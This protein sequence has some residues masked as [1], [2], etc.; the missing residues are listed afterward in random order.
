V[1]VND[2]GTL[3]EANDLRCVSLEHKL[4]IH[5]SP[6]AVMSYGDGG[7][8]LGYL[9]GEPH[10]GLEYM[11][12]MMNNARLGVG[13]QGVGV[14][15][16]AYQAARAYAFE[17]VQSRPMDGST[18]DPV[19]IAHHPDVRR[20]LLS[21][22]ALAET[23]R[24][25]TYYAASCLD[26]AK[27]H[28]DPAVRRYNQALVDLLIPVVKA[29]NTDNAVEVASL[30]VQVHGGMGYV[31]ET[32]AAQY[33]R[34]ARITPIYEGTNGIQAL[35][36]VGRKVAREKA[37][38]VN[39]FMALVRG[40]DK[41]LA[42]SENDAIA[43]IRAQLAAATDSLEVATA[44]LVRTYAD[45]PAAVGAGAVHYLKLLAFVAGGWLMARAALIA[46]DKLDLGDGNADFLQGKI[47]SARFFANHYL[48]QA[49]M[50]ASVFMRGAAAV[51]VVEND[52]L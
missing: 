3:G 44:W 45:N 31:E 35:D 27:R 23:G 19:A 36:L 4:G 34:D 24:A 51:Q 33:F 13:L 21:M 50:L 25:L 43:D 14:S 22:K 52:W 1:L 32:G 48:V 28:S 5:A 15:D 9:V 49:D 17:R 26:K 10:R 42:A 41:E 40:L 39:S 38:T 46:D 7:G 8:A 29:W 16:R 18:K 47:V 37:L 2:D 30:G 20:M 11:F 6:T 12:T